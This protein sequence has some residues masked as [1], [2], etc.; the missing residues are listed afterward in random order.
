M[1]NILLNRYIL[2]LKIYYLYHYNKGLSVYLYLK[3]FFVE[4]SNTKKSFTIYC[5]NTFQHQYKIQ[6]EIQ[7]ADN[8][9]EIFAGKKP[10]N[11]ISK[12]K[13]AMYMI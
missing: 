9:E 12:E 2:N 13:N 4:G 3:P 10:S 8:W 7:K 5:I 6:K 1:G 11:G